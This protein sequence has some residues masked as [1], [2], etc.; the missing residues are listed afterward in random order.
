ML[1]FLLPRQLVNQVNTDPAVNPYGNA[2]S[3]A[4]YAAYPTV[5]KAAWWSLP[6]SLF[7]LLPSLFTLQIYDRVIYRNGYATLVALIAGILFFLMVELWLRRKRSGALRDAGSTIDHGVSNAL[8]KSMLQR[9]LR[10]LESRPTMGWFLLFRDVGAVRATVTGGL[11]TSIFDLPVAIFA[12]IIVGVVAWPLLP[13][14]LL[15]LAVLAFFAWWWADEVRAGRVEEVQRGRNLDAVTSEICRARE[16]LKSL[17]NDA[18]IIAMWRKN[19]NAWL[20]ESFRKNGEI[21]GARELTTVMLS[22]FSVVLISV[23][24]LAVMEQWMTVGGSSLPTCWP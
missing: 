10:A 21:E 15:F 3:E 22:V 5:K 1:K 20:A 8:L 23:G 14:L 24:A 2:L 7:G 12:L 9:P 6:I 19:Y 4:F 11:V 16:T 17:G 13:V 18:P